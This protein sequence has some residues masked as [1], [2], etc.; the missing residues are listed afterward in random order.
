MQHSAD[1]AFG[2]RLQRQRVHVT[3]GDRT[4]RLHEFT[5]PSCAAACVE[6]VQ[7]P[8]QPGSLALNRTDDEIMKPHI[9]PVAVFRRTHRM[10][11]ICFHFLRRRLSTSN[12][13]PESLRSLAAHGHRRTGTLEHHVFELGDVMTQLRVKLL[14]RW[15]RCCDFEVL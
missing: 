14:K 5:Q 7:R 10:V 8:P 12:A 3:A 1:A 13:R 15:K 11:F 9:P 6:D 2:G 4:E